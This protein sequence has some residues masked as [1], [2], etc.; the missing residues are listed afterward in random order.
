MLFEFSINL[1]GELTRLLGKFSVLI[2]RPI[3]DELI[4]LSKHGKGKKK[5]NSK[6]ALDLI[7]KY[8]I[9]DA[10]GKGD[11]S[12]L[13]LAKKYNGIVVTNDRDLRKR[14]KEIHLQT[15]YLREKSKL[16]LD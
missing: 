7:K 12:V 6:P 15:I 13:F 14:A 8:E 16:V 5:Y 10:E 11:D 2:P 4:I 3:V 1:E 9:S